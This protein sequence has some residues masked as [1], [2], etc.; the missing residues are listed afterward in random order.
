MTVPAP[1]FTL[2]PSWQGWPLVVVAVL[3]IGLAGALVALGSFTSADFIAVAV[4]L[5]AMLGMAAVVLG[6][7]DGPGR[8]GRGRTPH[9]PRT[10]DPWYG[11]PKHSYPTTRAGETVN[12][13]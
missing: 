1:P 8:S 13:N 6:V 11:L 2:E 7:A 9:R 12:H 4:P 10:E 5:V 3:V